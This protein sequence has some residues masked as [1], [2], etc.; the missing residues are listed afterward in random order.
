MKRTVFLPT[1]ACVLFVS[2]PAWADEKSGFYLGVG[3]GDFSTDVDSLDDVGVDLDKDTDAAKA[4]IGWRV[5]RALA[6]QLDYFD[7]DKSDGSALLD[8]PK[9]KSDLRGASASLVATLPVGPLELFVKGGWMAYELK[10]RRHDSVV[11]DKRETEPI[12][13][14]GIGFTIF[15]RFALRAEYEVFDIGEIEDA[16]AAWLT[17]AWRF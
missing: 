15:K 10:V 1:L 7:L 12:Y 16:E 17:A 4:F 11:F 13:G 8:L 5:N 2:A 6:L 14:G 9:G 3:L